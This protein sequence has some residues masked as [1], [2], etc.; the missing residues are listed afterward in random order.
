MSQE[1][2]RGSIFVD[3]EK[4]KYPDNEN[5]TLKKLQFKINKGEIIG[6]MGRTGSGKTSTL[7]LLNGLI[8]HFFEGDFKG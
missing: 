4:Y 6:V 7:M 2:V 8:P 3:L 1:L 5:E